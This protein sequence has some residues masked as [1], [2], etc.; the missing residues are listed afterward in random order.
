MSD[1]ETDDEFLSADEGEDESSTKHGNKEVKHKKD[2]RQKSMFEDEL[3]DKNV[4]LNESKLTEEVEK[5][6]SSIQNKPDNQLD[7]QTSSEVITKGNTNKNN[8][9][10][11]SNLNLEE[12]VE[13]Q[14]IEKIENNIDL[15]LQNLNCAERE[16][17]VN[18]EDDAIQ[19][20]GLQDICNNI[21]VQ[22]EIPK[23]CVTV[24]K[25]TKEEF[26]ANFS[27]TTCV[28]EDNEELS[29]N[30]SNDDS[31]V[32]NSTKKSEPKSVTENNLTIDPIGESEDVTDEYSTKDSW[33]KPENMTEKDST[34]KITANISRV[35]PG[36]K[37]ADADDNDSTIDPKSEAKYL[38][39]NSSTTNSKSV[40]DNT[41][42][43]GTKEEITSPEISE[44][45]DAASAKS[46]TQAS[47]EMSDSFSL[48]EETADN[49]N[50]ST[51][52]WGNW[53][54][55][56]DDFIA[57]AAT[58]VSNLL[59]TVEGQLGIPDPV[60][61]AKT[62]KAETLTKP[63]DKPSDDN[64]QNT[65]SDTEVKEEGN[66]PAAGGSWFSSFIPVSSLTNIVQNTGQDLVS[67]SIDALEFL[68][69]KTV[70]M[71]AE[72]D[73]G[74]RGT[75]ENLFKNQKVT[76]SSVLQEARESTKVEA[77]KKEEV[78]NF[79]DMFEKFQGTAHLDALQMNSNECERKL[80]RILKFQ[81]NEIKEESKKLLDDIK[82]RFEIKEDENQEEYNGDFKKDLFQI[83]KK[84][85]LK[86]T[87]SKTLNTWTKLNDKLNDTVLE[88]ISQ[89]AIAS[90]AEFTS[91]CIGF[92]RK[93]AD[94]LIVTDMEAKDLCIQRAEN[95]NKLTESLQCQLSYFTK[96]YVDKLVSLEDSSQLITDLYIESSNCIS[97]ITDSHLLIL[98]ILQ[99]SAIK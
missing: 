67:G 54:T 5:N 33:T 53:D 37:P 83:T 59:E 49:E 41:I 11:N 25:T 57:D 12:S 99:C 35:Y 77:E 14:E 34:I 60:E 72:G 75:R 66:K 27:P 23:E 48:K 58:K 55:W 69:K 4:K 51:A 28:V 19:S 29:E 56:A 88:D 47:V 68:G 32:S 91:R 2:H 1:T 74:L 52:G 65:E 43:S 21:I 95:L 31:I 78:V 80:D 61:M 39:D 98:P 85:K 86:V 36:S 38:I 42:S 50:S 63:A 18:I 9:I 10:L 16:A 7:E 20:K 93:I 64:N 94:M 45:N 15:E 92:H 40:K 79:L 26:V 62:V 6:N 90:F 97:M 96:V 71:I 82:E 87:C 70:G 17:D 46:D 44:T 73:P 22:Q 76:L 84:L 24:E 30:C 13:I 3:K 8:K 89:T 81:S